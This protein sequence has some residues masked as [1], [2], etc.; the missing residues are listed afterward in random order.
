MPLETTVMTPKKIVAL[1]FAI[2]TVG[3][4]IWLLSKWSS[5]DIIAK[6]GTFILLTAGAAIVAA[7]F[8]LPAAGEW[9]G[10]LF[11]SAPEEVE[12]DKYHDAASK[13][14]QGDYQGAIKAYRAIAKDEPDTRFPIVEIAKIQQEHLHDGDAAINSIQTALDS[15]EWAENDAA[16]FMFRLADLHQTEKNDEETAKAYLNRVIETFPET[17]HSANATHKL[18]EIEQAAQR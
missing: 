5:M 9:I 17:R 10:N 14:A 18:H 6:F 8:V 13:L 11:Y 4:G 7:V 2:L 15:K 16:Y 12:P 1:N 3:L